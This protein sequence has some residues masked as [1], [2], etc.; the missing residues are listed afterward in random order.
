MEHFH[1]FGVWV[2]MWEGV[3][4][5]IVRGHNFNTDALKD[6]GCE[7]GRCTIACGTDHAQFTRHFEIADQIVDVGFAHA[8]DKFVS[9]TCSGNATAFKYDSAQFVH[10]VG[11]VGEGTFKSHFYACPTVWI[12]ACCDHSNG[13][14]V[15]MKLTEI[16]HGRH[17]RADVFHMDARLHESQHQSVFYGKRIIAIV[18]SDSYNWLDSARMHLCPEADAE[19]GYAGKIDFL[20]ILPSGVVFA[21]PSWGD[22]GITQKGPS[23]RGRGVLG[24]HKDSR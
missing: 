2:V 14:G 13:R 11:A 17:G 18:I 23:V 10:L 1:G 8:F 6:F 21:K 9:A 3:I 19:C 24:Q 15:E 7:G 20:R 12:V 4:K 5:L 22:H 16:G